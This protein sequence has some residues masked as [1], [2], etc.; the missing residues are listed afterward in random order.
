MQ[1]LLLLLEEWI[2]E[3]DRQSILSHCL[4]FYGHAVVYFISGDIQSSEW[5]Q[6]VVKVPQVWPR[7]RMLQN[8][9]K[10]QNRKQKKK[11]IYIV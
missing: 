2:Y 4:K 9:E 5:A 3:K 1:H 7:E 6:M 10:D 11:Y 8:D